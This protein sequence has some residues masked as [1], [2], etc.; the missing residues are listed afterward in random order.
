MPEYPPILL[1]S[2]LPPT[3]ISVRLIVNAEGLVTDVQSLDADTSAGFAVF[4]ASVR[5]ACRRW[6]YTPMMQGILDSERQPDGSIVLSG[7]ATEK[8]LPFHLDYAFRFSQD[9]GQP[10]VNAGAS[11]QPTPEK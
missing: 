6:K 7:N 9:D 1:P 3:V 4:L 8:P 2:R 5:E 10:A 11:D